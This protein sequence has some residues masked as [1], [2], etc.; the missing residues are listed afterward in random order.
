MMRESAPERAANGATDGDDGVMVPGWRTPLSGS[1]EKETTG[2]VWEGIKP[3]GYALASGQD[4]H[5]SRLLKS[6]DTAGRGTL[7]LI[8]DLL[9]Y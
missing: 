2:C 7:G 6:R 1:K 5:S 4:N 9:L 8:Y 3:K